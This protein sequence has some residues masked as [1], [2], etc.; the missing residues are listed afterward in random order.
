MLKGL[1]KMIFDKFREKIDRELYP[2]PVIQNNPYTKWFKL[3]LANDEQVKD[4]LIQFSVF[5]MWFL[6]IEC[7]RMARAAGTPSERA[8]RIILA[9]ELGVGL[10]LNTHDIEGEKFSH[11][12]AHIEWLRKMGD[13]LGIDRAILGRWERAHDSTKKFLKNL[14]FVYANSDSNVGA[15]AS[16]AIESWAGFGIGRGILE[17]QNN[18]WNE[19]LAGLKKYNE[20]RRAEK[21]EPIYDGFFRYHFALE[22]G[23]VANVEDELK[24]IFSSPD[25]NGRKWFYGARKAL[26]AIYIFWTG[27]DEARRA[28]EK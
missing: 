7:E 16:F 18:F 4:L 5:S 20:K 24:E 6:V 17:E 9:S 12:D 21:L 8:S 1:R 27:L 28:L 3:G 10:N 19:L 14:K 15:G 26:D 11:S 23:H 22:S 13:P 25:F 2:H